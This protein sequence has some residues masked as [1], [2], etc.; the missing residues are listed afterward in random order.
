MACT[1]VW[2]AEALAASVLL[3]SVNRVS[4]GDETERQANLWLQ[5]YRLR[6]G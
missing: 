5:I 3:G 4:P 6:L 2:R 1:S